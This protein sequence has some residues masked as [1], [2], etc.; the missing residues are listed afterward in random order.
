MIRE[1]VIAEYV[2]G[3]KTLDVGS[4]GQTDAYR[5]WDMIDAHASSLTGIDLDDTAL[6][7]LGG[8]PTDGAPP[9]PRILR[10]DVETHSFGESFEAI[11]VG[12]V[13]EH[14]SN[15]G[16]FLDNCKRHLTHDGVLVVTTPNAKWPTVF[17]RP[18]PTHVLWHDRHTILHLLDRH[19]FAVRLFR[20]YCGNKPR[21]ALPLRLLA[22]RQAM[23]VVAGHK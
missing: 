13:I 7:A 6:A 15:P 3:R 22:W 19:G 21:Y 17:L 11:V 1:A 16:V 8:D 5:L 23:L 18:N 20:Y 10:G 2:R 4:L 9:D 12:D 14:L